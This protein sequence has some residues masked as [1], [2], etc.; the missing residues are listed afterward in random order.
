MA[1][2]VRRAARSATTESSCRGTG[3]SAASATW[4]WRDGR[5][6]ARPGSSSPAARFAKHDHPMR[7]TSWSP[8]GLPGDRRRR[9]L[10]GH[11]EPH[12][13]NHYRRSVAHNTMLVTSQ[14]SPSSG[15]E[16]LAGRQRRRPAHGL[17]ALLEQRQEPRGLPARATSGTLPAR[18]GGGAQYRYARADATRL[19]AVEAR[20]LHPRAG[21]S[22]RPDILPCSTASARPI[23]PS[24]RP[25]CPLAWARKVKPRPRARAPATGASLGL[26][27]LVRGRP[28]PAARAPA[29]ARARGDRPRRRGPRVLDAG[30]RARR[31]LGLSQNWPARPAQGGRCDDP[32]LR[33]MWLTFWDGIEKLSPSNRRAVVPGGWRI[34]PKTGEGDVFLHDRDRRPRRKRAGPRASRATGSR[35]RRSRTTTVLFASAADGKRRCRTSDTAP[36]RRMACRVLHPVTSVRAG[37]AG[38]AGERRSGRR[39]HARVSLGWRA[40]RPP[41]PEAPGSRRSRRCFAP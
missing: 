4:C 33:K 24:A 35:G 22:A 15:R 36:A 11:R 27:R 26:A 38:L 6:T 9:R 37:V 25:G 10:H 41:A 5:A 7:R 20:A 16:P 3:C 1:G 19:P 8:Q 14:A 32:Y 34:S 23:P 21:A 28:G 17:V 29:A 13:L 12:Y 2:R 40:R 31:C 39:R 30:R 18:S